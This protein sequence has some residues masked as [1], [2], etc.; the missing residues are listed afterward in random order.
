MIP[1]GAEPDSIP[2]K[3]EGSSID[4]GGDELGVL[5]GN[6]LRR[7]RTRNGYSL[8]TPGEALR[9]QPRMLG[10][11]ELGRS[12]PTIALL[13][14]VARALDVPFATLLE[15]RTPQSTVVFRLADAKVLRSIDGS[16][17]SRALFPVDSEAAGRVL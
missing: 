9:G 2:E 14:K 15:T 13:W 16:F 17:T 11:I 12:V 10:Q 4:L 3:P 5:V 7:L 8:E 1:S 6:N